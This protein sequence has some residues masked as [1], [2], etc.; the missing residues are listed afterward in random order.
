MSNCNW[1]QPPRDGHSR[2]SVLL[3]LSSA[4]TD[5]NITDTSAVISFD[6]KFGNNHISNAIGCQVKQIQIPNMFNNVRN[7][8]NIIEFQYPEVVN[9][10]LTGELRRT[11]INIPVGWYNAEDLI[12]VLN[13][14]FHT[15]DLPFDFT[16]QLLNDYML[17]T[18]GPMI[19]WNEHALMLSFDSPQY[20]D[21][22]SGFF[23]VEVVTE[24]KISGVI[25]TTHVEHHMTE[26]VFPPGVIN[27]GNAR[28]IT[29]VRCV[30]DQSFAIEDDTQP[31]PDG[32]ITDPSII[33]QTVFNTTYTQRELD[34]GSGVMYDI[35]SEWKA[36]LL[37]AGTY[38]LIHDLYPG[39]VRL[40]T[41][42]TNPV[43]EFQYLHGN[44]DGEISTKFTSTVVPLDDAYIHGGRSSVW[45]GQGVK[46]CL[47][48]WNE[49]LPYQNPRRNSISLPTQ[50]VDGLSCNAMLVSVGTTHTP[51]V[52]TSPTA[53]V[54]QDI[55]THVMGWDTSEF[56]SE[57]KESDQFVV[58]QGAHQINL[59]GQ[60]IVYV[61]SNVL[62]PSN[63]VGAKT[64]ITT[65][66]LD[67]VNMAD[68]VRGGYSTH[69]PQD[70]ETSQ[71]V[72]RHAKTV[73]HVDITIGDIEGR[74]LEFPHNY[75]A[76][77]IVK[78][79]S[80]EY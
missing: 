73:T 13:L 30:N 23:G 11:L 2:S 43:N 64:K 29:L 40:N 27:V 1:G 14:A 48:D 51:Y 65:D 52:I 28:R 34:V 21:W 57:S 72:W 80:E 3:T 46:T 47:G 10:D 22:E 38:M 50:S 66:L 7:G 36:V 56:H 78:I 71:V 42:I 9:G 32:V 76:T 55:L 49:D 15:S 8:L 31:R 41:C 26:V 68:V 61:Y 77:V 37:P 62:A 67:T 35:A 17:F 12:A 5:R 6:T 54:H 53:Y 18:A 20:D 25:F 63:G 4:E 74:K 75:P 24:K 39:E 33:V 69:S 70:P 79:I 58:Y 59:S 45:S 19:N 16:A 60:T 44:N